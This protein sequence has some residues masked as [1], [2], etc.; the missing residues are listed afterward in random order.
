[1]TRPVTRR[2]AGEPLTRLETRAF[3]LPIVLGALTAVLLA[4]C[5][6]STTPS[7]SGRSPRR[8]FAVANIGKYAVCMRGHGVS[9]FP[10]PQVSG[11]HVTMTVTPAITGSPAFAS[12]QKACAYILP[13]PAGQTNGQSPAA[14]KARIQ[15]MI[16]FAACM[17]AH[18][19]P[20]FPDPTSQG[21]LTL[22]MIRQAGIKLQQPAVPKAGD[23]CVSA[24]HGQITKG[25]VAR[26]VSDSPTSGANPTGAP[27]S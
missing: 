2:S 9:D 14:Q 19:F 16:A 4:A 7:A 20:S 22:A 21:Q 3:P 6:G 5:G 24:S 26:A 1:M 10:D 25:D 27:G 12:A 15:G 18:G 13:A 8:A 11:N 23:A 17:R